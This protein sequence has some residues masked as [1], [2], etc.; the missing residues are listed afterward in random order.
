MATLKEWKE[1]DSTCPCHE[2]YWGDQCVGYINWHDR[3]VE[4]VYFGD[5]DTIWLE[6][7]E[8]ETEVEFS[9][10]LLKFVN[11]NEQI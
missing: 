7:K 5:D 9:K 8:N 4:I 2:I 3:D 1:P 10:R 11:A 6:Q